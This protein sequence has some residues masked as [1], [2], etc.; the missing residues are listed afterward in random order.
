MATEP[1]SCHNLPGMS[2]TSIIKTFDVRRA[3]SQVE[4]RLQRM[5][6]EDRAQTLVKAGILTPKGKVT[7]PYAKVFGSGK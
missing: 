4:K 2:E 1:G 6:N 5:S 3:W 7:K